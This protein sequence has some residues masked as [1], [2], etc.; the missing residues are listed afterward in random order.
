MAFYSQCRPVAC[1]ADSPRAMIAQLIRVVLF[2]IAKVVTR[3][4]FS[5]EQIRSLPPLDF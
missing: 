4:G 5:C 1:A 2:A 3:V